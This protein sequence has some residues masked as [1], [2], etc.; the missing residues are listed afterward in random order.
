VLPDEY[1]KAMIA[2][3]GDVAQSFLVDGMVAGTWSVQ[4][5][6]VSI[7]PFEPLPSKTREEIRREADRLEAFL[8]S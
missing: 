1:R 7:R 5:G 2:T 3:N 4:G 8:R 6:A